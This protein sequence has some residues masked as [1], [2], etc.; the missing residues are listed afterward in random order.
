MAK[1]LAT[2]FVA[3]LIGPGTQDIGGNKNFISTGAIK[4]PTGTTA[5]RPGSPTN[6]MIRYNSDLT[7][8][9]GYASNTWS[10]IGGSTVKDR[11]T[12]A[13][14]G[15]AVGDVLY[16]NGSTYTKARADI[17]ATAEVVGLVSRI[18][19]TNTFEVTLNGEVSGLLASS[20]TE[21]S[22]PAAGE[23]VFLSAT[24]AGKLTITEPSIFGQVSLPIGVASGSGTL[25]VT[26]KRGA[27]VGGVNVRSFIG[28]ANS[29]TTS[30]QNV[31][32]YDAGE[33]TGWVELSN[34]TSANSKK[35]YIS[36]QFAKNG[37]GTDYNVAYQ[38]AG[39]TPPAGF[40]VGYSANNVQIT[41]PNISGLTTSTINFALNAPSIGATLP[42]S[43]DSSTVQF[44]TVQAKNASGISVRNAANTVTNL[45]ISD[46]GS[47]GLGTSSPTSTLDIEGSV[48]YQYTA[49]TGATTLNAT[50]YYVSAS[51]A[52]TYA[53]TLP[54][55]ASIA[56]RVYIIKSN[57]NAGILLTVN[58][59]SA[60]TID[61]ATSRS[62]ARFESLQVISNGTNWEI[63]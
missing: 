61:G 27:I 38:T 3:G 25:Y 41:L 53:V 60:Q 15:F 12:Q 28:L 51:G 22:L 63:F 10:E 11:V 35:F 30:I 26:P 34:S 46:T 6:G 9:E 42:L 32:A 45:F 39:D 13:S 33:L 44:G 24:T 4:V 50:Q 37:P 1:N 58:T 7:T 18:V 57:M 20:Y 59:T 21:N 43:I 36:I 23:A 5:E 62:L 40:S 17:A 52:S 31:S 47:V 48:T 54:T 19:D 56:G 16:L 2:P 55:A 14:H 29:A 8:F 49:V